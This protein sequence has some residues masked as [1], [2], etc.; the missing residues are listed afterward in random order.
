MSIFQK[1]RNI[2]NTDSSDDYTDDTDY[3]MFNSNIDKLEKTS[4]YA[5]SPYMAFKI[6]KQNDNLKTNFFRRDSRYISYLSFDDCK[7]ELVDGDNNRKYYL[8][9]ITKGQV[10][11]ID[12]ETFYDGFL[13]KKDFALL[14][15]LV[16][17]ET[18]EYFYYPKK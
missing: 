16:D 13:T 10:S 6:A 12:G 11:W 14:Q 1:I 9:N 17:V 5:I 2:F 18:G 4:Q 15:C 8:V 7:V 3:Y